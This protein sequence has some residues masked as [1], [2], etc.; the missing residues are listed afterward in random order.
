LLILLLILILFLM[1]F[2]M[3][4]LFLR[5]SRHGSAPARRAPVFPFSPSVD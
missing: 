2:L 1:L 3:L 4:F 5:L